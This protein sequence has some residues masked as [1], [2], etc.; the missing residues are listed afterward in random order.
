MKPVNYKKEMTFEELNSLGL[1]E[2]RKAFKMAQE[3]RKGISFPTK[4]QI[5]MQKVSQ[6]NFD[7]IAM[8]LRYGK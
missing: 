3:E 4:Q 8:I 6:V 2:L 1:D 7:K 5:K